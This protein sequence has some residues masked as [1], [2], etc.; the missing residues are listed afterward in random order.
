MKKRFTSTI[1]RLDKLKLNHLTIPIQVLE[2]IRLEDDQ[3]SVYNQRII[4]T[5]NNQL[6]WNGG[7]VALGDGNAYISIS[8][9]RMTELGVNIGDVVQV[10]IERD[11]SEYGMP[12]PEEFE[13]VL[14][15]DPIA[16][17]RFE[18]LSKG[19][20]RAIIYLI[21]QSKSVDKRIEKSLFF[22]QNLKN[23]PK[24]DFNMRHLIGK[25]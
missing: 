13:A 20:R 17:E 15:Q 19:K 3:G 16:K 25:E 14:E 6:T 11:D 8:T 10:E 2:E 7:T 4:V 24:G 21:S 9:K 1:Q 23:M 5:V 12:V 22:M 18:L